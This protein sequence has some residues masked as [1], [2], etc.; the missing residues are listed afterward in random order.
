MVKTEQSKNSSKAL[1]RIVFLAMFSAM[2]FV[3]YL[4]EVPIFPAQ[5]H[6]KL[7]FGDIPALIGG[8]LFGPGF[9]VL[10]ELIKNAIELIVRGFGSQM[11]FGNIMNFIV[12]CAFIVPFSLIFRRMTGNKKNRKVMAAVVAGIASVVSILFFGAAGNY[13]VAPLFFKYFLGIEFSKAALWSAIGWA[14]ALNAVK[15]AILWIVALPLVAVIKERLGKEL[16][17]GTGD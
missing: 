8:I 10:V 11:G 14:T 6:L 13:V 1:L 4:L 9:A 12:G 17:K 15:G 3:L 5:P 7:D 2:A 16:N